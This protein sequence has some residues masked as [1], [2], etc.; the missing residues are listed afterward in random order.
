MIL[1]WQFINVY[2]L[3]LCMAKEKI[4]IGDT[5]HRKYIP[6]HIN[7]TSNI[8]TITCVC[9]TC[10]DSMLLQ[11]GLNQLQLIK[12]YKFEKHFHNSTP[13]S[14]VQIWKVLYEACRNYVCQKLCTNLW[15]SFWFYTILSLLLSYDQIKN[16][17]MV[18][19]Y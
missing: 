7:P 14:I 19:N 9:E 18:L 16:P 8:N 15:H 4:C 5:S 2:F 12:L 11:S 13:T 3:V 10:N 17:E 6:K 1:F